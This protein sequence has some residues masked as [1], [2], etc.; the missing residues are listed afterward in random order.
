MKRPNLRIIRIKENEDYQIKGPENVFNKNRRRKLPQPK[1]S[2]RHK[3]TR[4]L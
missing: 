3:G 4:N 1:E 2:N